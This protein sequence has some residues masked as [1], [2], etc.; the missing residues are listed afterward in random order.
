VLFIPLRPR[1]LD[2][3]QPRCSTIG[4]TAV[5]PPQALGCRL[6]KGPLDQLVMP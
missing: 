6:R 2:E 4:V 3:I 1:M 5:R